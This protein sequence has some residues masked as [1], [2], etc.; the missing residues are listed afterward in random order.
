MQHDEFLAAEKLKPKGN[1]RLREGEVFD[2]IELTCRN[3]KWDQLY[4]IAPGRNGV[5]FLQVR[6]YIPYK[7]PTLSE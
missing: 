1:T 6:A 3:T 2:V 7:E 5:K 4:G